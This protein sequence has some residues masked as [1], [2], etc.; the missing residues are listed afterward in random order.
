MLAGLS[1]SR[2]AGEL[3]NFESLGPQKF[4]SNAHESHQDEPHEWDIRRESLALQKVEEN[5]MV[6]NIKGEETFT[7]N[8][9]TFRP[10]EPNNSF[11]HDPQND[12]FIQAEFRGYDHNNHDVNEVSFN[13]ELGMH[14]DHSG[15]HDSFSHQ[16]DSF[17]P[18]NQVNSGYGGVEGS[19]FLKN[20]QGLKHLF[21]NNTI[22]LPEDLGCDIEEKT[23]NS[24][25]TILSNVEI[26]AEWVSLGSK[27]SGA[28]GKIQ[29]TQ[30]VLLTTSTPLKPEG[31]ESNKNMHF[32]TMESTLTNF[33]LR[34]ITNAVAS[35]KGTPFSEAETP[36]KRLNFNTEN[37]VKSTQNIEK[38]ENLWKITCDSKE[39]SS[40]LAQ[41]Y[42]SGTDYQERLEQSRPNFRGRVL[43]FS[44]F[45]KF[46]R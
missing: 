28:N 5:S 29:S 18:F 11:D 40:E 19:S 44:K 6:L 36:S 4:H 12:N 30:E 42:Q 26:G 15:N 38:T 10:T 23:S 32:E 33:G 24:L 31:G 39:N 22:S 8:I 13:N 21:G 25:K 14:I 43:D 27:D 9:D 17:V 3:Q 35:V 16:Q 41:S 37:T 46:S 34:E 1:E 7:Q 45:I 2:F 20:P